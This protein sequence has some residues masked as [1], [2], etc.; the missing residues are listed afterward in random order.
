M[1]DATTHKTTSEQDQ[2]ISPYRE[3]YLAPYSPERGVA[4]EYADRL[5]KSLAYRG[6]ANLTKAER[7]TLAHASLATGLNPYIGEIWA[8]HDYGLM[9]GR[10]GWVKKLGELGEKQS[11]TSWS[12]YSLLQHHEYPKYSVP[13][14]AQIAFICEIRRSDWLKIYNEALQ[15][16]S[17]SMKL[18]YDLI[19]ELLGKP[20][21]AR[22]VGFIRKGEDFS[23]SA[24]PLAERAK[25]RAFAQACRE[26]VYLPFD[27]LAEGDMVNGQALDEPNVIEA[28]YQVTTPK[29]EIKPE[30]APF[31]QAEKEPFGNPETQEQVAADP[32][33]APDALI[34]QQA[35]LHEQ[36]EPPE[37]PTPEKPIVK[38]QAITPAAGGKIPV[39]QAPKPEPKPK[40]RPEPKPTLKKAE[41]KPPEPIK[42]NGEDITILALKR[43]NPDTWVIAAEMLNKE[44]KVHFTAGQLREAVDKKAGSLFTPM[45]AGAWQTAIEVAQEAAKSK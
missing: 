4:L 26:F 41:E 25:K 39:G 7:L 24:M 9:V 31:E 35:E 22:G 40:A 17:K 16:L 18:E 19:I 42:D 3:R 15:D 11:F 12:Q 23:K 20:P 33:P 29:T 37:P 5:E 6:A 38:A 34:K 43:S 21:V 28:D 14:D 32:E 44:L 8:I 2:A 30:P 36:Q 45:G 1:I 27:V 13:D 10:M